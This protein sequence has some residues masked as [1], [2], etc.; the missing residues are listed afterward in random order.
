MDGEGVGCSLMPVM[1]NARRSQ[2]MGRCTGA[3]NLTTTIGMA[4]SWPEIRA[5]RG[6]PSSGMQ[7]DRGSNYDGDEGCRFGAGEINAGGIIGGTWE[8]NQSTLETHELIF[9]NNLSHEM[10]NT[11]MF[12]SRSDE[13]L[14]SDFC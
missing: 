9:G 1:D 8:E 4:G 14:L 2:R 11:S 12:L 6:V 10:R 13:C 7:M 5:T 3:V